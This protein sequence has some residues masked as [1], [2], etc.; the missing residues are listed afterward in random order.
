MLHSENIRDAVSGKTLRMKK[1]KRFSGRSKIVFV[2][3]FVTFV[4]YAVLLM[5]PYAYSLQVSLMENGRAFMR[6]RLHLPWPPH[7]KNYYL[8][9]TELVDE[10]SGA[11][12]LMMTLNSLWY[13]LGTSSLGL[14]ASTCTAYAICKYKFIGRNFIYNA[15]IVI[16]MIPIFGSLPAQYKL[17]NALN[18]TNSPLYLITSFG[19]LG[20]TFIYIY[21]FFKSISWSYAEAAFID[22]AGH[23]RVFTTIMVPMLMPSLSALFIIG[24]IGGWNDYMGPMLWLSDMPTLALGLWEYEAKI[25]YTANQPVY[26]AGVVISM[27][28]ILVIFGLFQNTIMDNVYAGGL[29]G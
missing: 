21:A 13:A 4:I 9:I 5:Y 24:F 25:M 28:P 12:F 8:A 7:I 20:G 6:D 16:M 18:I 29:K 23:M 15:V 2:I 3:V 1:G 11:N 19:G 10:S 22:G 17:F 14:I 26:F 27:L